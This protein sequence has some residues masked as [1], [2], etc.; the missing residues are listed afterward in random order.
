MWTHMGEFAKGRAQNVTDRP[1]NP[2][3]TAE[4]EQSSWPSALL[5]S[6][7]VLGGA[8]RHGLMGNTALP[9]DGST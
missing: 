1:P 2:A 9:L 3:V 4:T 7:V 8:M 5:R 6:L